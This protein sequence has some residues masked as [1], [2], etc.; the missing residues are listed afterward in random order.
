M[1]D[2]TTAGILALTLG[3]F[4]V[5]RF[6]LGQTFLGILYIFIP[7][8][9]AILGIIDGVLLLTMNQEVFDAKYNRDRSQRADRRARRAT[10][11][12]A[13]RRRRSNP[14]QIKPRHRVDTSTSAPVTN[15]ERTERAK[16]KVEFKKIHAQGQKYFKDYQFDEAEKAYLQALSLAPNHPKLLYDLACLYAMKEDATKGFEYLELA[17][18]KGFKDIDDIDTNPTLAYLRIQDEFLDFAK[19]GYK[20]AYAKNEE[21]GVELLEQLRQLDILRSRGLLTEIEF[22][23]ERKKL[24]R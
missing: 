24:I 3:V 5:H 10:K 19:A 2:K 20:S 7:P 6:Y 17:V 1:R 15:H 16:R 8:L 12:D 22:E 9:S 11:R 14:S 18:F 23:E 4:G 13:R 21:H